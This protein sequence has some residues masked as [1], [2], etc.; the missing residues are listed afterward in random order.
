MGKND[1][2]ANPLD[3]P[4]MRKALDELIENGH[5]QLTA[6]D[7]MTK[8]NVNTMVTALMRAVTVRDTEIRLTYK[9][10]AMALCAWTWT[11]SA[12][13]KTLA[14]HNLSHLL[15]KKKSSA[16]NIEFKN[17]SGIMFWTEEDISKEDPAVKPTQGKEGR[18]CG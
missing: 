13:E 10:T 15:D 1:K 5:Q 14:K 3:T 11:L 18:A 17:G 7:K 9:T 12:A 6:T 16:F 2:K 8:D 4:T